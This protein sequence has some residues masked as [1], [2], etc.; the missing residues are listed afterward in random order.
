MF[1]VEQIRKDFPMLRGL[2]MQDKPLIFFD[3][4]ATSLKPQ[5]VIDAIVNYYE[6]LGS[7]AHRGDYDISYQVDNIFEQTR[8][9]IANF[10]NCDANE[11]IYTSGASES[12]NLVAQG[13]GKTFLNKQ[14]IVLTSIAEHA[15]CI[16]PWMQVCEETGAIIKYIPLDENS[17]ISIEQFE[18]MM[19]KQVKVVAIAQVGNV[20][21]TS[22]DIKAIC[23]IA[24]KYGAI[25]LVDGAQSV[26]HQ[27]IDVQ[28]LGCDFLAFS[29]HKMCGPT[30]L[31]ILY[32]KYSLLENM[33]PFLLGGGSNARYDMCGNILMKK[34]PHKFESGTPPIAEVFGFQAAIA[35]LN[36]I[37][38]DEIYK[39]E[40]MLTKYAQE[41]MQKMDNIILYNPHADAG[42]LTFNVVDVFAQDAASYF[43]FNGIAVR[44]GQHCAKLLN[45]HLNTSATIRVS[46][47]FYNT[48]AEIDTFLGVAAKANPTTCLD[49]FF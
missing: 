43:N 18:L 5:C 36:K 8:S 22:I 27:K 44:S 25:V 19:S 26:P 48:I 24:H 4:S 15:S 47:Y 37:G 14:D 1:N 9:D 28:A 6:N 40:H 45:D 34:P 38:M 21:G 20:L 13:Y 30:G 2:K 11:I 23:E 3:N 42:I 16:L 12:L 49:I 32:G 33:K 41:K 10:I 29:A 39:Y 46:F 17:S 7:N 31:G 35:Y